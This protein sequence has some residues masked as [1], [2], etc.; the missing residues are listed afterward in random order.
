MIK[1]FATQVT[2]NDKVIGTVKEMKL[3][4]TIIMI[5]SGP[6]IPNIW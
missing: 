6:Q 3:L 5:S 1:Q 2:M 4:R